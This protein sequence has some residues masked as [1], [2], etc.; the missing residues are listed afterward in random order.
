ML[1]HRRL[2]VLRDILICA[3]ICYE[4]SALMSAESRQSH[5]QIRIVLFDTLESSR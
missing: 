3:E 5:A 4:M 1:R 2:A